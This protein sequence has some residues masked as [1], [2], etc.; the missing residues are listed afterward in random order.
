MDTRANLD[1]M[2]RTKNL[3]P[4]TAGDN[5]GGNL[6]QEPCHLSYLAL[7]VESVK[8]KTGSPFPKIQEVQPLSRKIFKETMKFVLKPSQII[9]P[10]FF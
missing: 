7:R 9:F 1:K 8:Y 5:P 3:Q 6:S 10:F 2:M 4:H